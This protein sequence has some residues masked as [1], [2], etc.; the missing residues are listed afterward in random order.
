MPNITIFD[1][2]GKFAMPNLALKCLM[3]PSST[4]DLTRLWIELTLI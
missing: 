4:N 2:L 1:I 3:I